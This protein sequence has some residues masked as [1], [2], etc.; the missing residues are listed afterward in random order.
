MSPSSGTSDEED[1]ERERKGERREYPTESSDDED[2]SSRMIIV[3]GRQNSND[4]NEIGMYF[5]GVTLLF[6]LYLIFYNVH[7]HV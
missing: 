7:V 2:S 4:S 6:P 5:G 3:E 1:E